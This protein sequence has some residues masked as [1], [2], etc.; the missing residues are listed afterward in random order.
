[1][2]R[3]E[4]KILKN[5][6]DE[7]IT[8]FPEAKDCGKFGVLATVSKDKDSF[9]LDFEIFPV[10][11]NF[12]KCWRTLSSSR[13]RVMILSIGFNVGQCLH[14]ARVV[15]QLLG[16]GSARFGVLVSAGGRGGASEVEN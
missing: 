1:M 13:L 10:M 4:V 14:R 5:T 15:G 16:D 2:H 7:W 8:C 11:T 3:Q 9:L 12:L 6:T